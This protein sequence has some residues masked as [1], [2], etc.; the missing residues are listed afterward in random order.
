MNQRQH[1]FVEDGVGRVGVVEQL[2]LGGVLRN[3]V[4]QPARGTRGILKI[5]AA[6]K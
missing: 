1:P 2:L 3:D 4:A 5:R 6:E